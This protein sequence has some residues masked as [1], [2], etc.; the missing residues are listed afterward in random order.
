[1]LNRLKS[2]VRFLVP[3]KS[4][5]ETGK[6]TTTI[7]ITKQLNGAYFILRKLGDSPFDSY[8]NVFRYQNWILELPRYVICCPSLVR[9]FKM[10]TGNKHFWFLCHI[11][12]YLLTEFSQG[13]IKS[14]DIKNSQG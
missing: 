4:E 14:E 5:T 7:T 10:K 13:L 1:M 8:T 11:F 9:L 3:P 12:S 2:W 6:Q